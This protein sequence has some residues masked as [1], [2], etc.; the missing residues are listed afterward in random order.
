LGSTYKWFHSKNGLNLNDEVGQAIGVSPHQFAAK[1]NH[2]FFDEPYYMHE[3]LVAQRG[4]FV[5]TT[6]QSDL[7]SS[8]DDTLRED[9]LKIRI[10]Q[11]WFPQVWKRLW[12]TNINSSILFPGIDGFSRLFKNDWT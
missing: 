7:Q 5:F 12:D 3:R 11:T 8:L 4:V 10:A 9:L 1:D 2:I 6:G